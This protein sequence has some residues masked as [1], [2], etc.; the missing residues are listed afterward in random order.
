MSTTL[1]E[2]NIYLEKA[3]LLAE[4][5]AKDAAERDKQGG[6]PKIQRDKIRESGLLKLLIPKEYGGEGQPW[7]LVLEVVREFAKTDAALAHLYGY[8]F[9]CLAGPYLAGSPDQIRHYFTETARHDYFWGN[10][11]NP[12]DKGIIGTR[13]GDQVI[14]NGSKSFSSGSPDSDLLI[15]SW[16]D[17]ETGDYYEGVLPTSRQGVHV[18]DD[19]DNI[20]QRQTGSGTVSFDHVTLNEQEILPT[21]YAA[22]NVFSTII[23]IIS[24]SILTNI[25]IGSALGAI[26]EAKKYTLK[27]SRAWYTS[28]YDKAAQDPWIISRYGNFWIEAQSALSFVEKAALALDRIWERG[29]DLTEEERGESAVIVAGANVLAGRVSLSICGDIFEVMG[30]RASASK[31]G[32]DRFWRNVRTHTLHNPAEYKKRTVGNWVLNGEFPKYGFYS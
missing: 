25:F 9:L 28:G 20:G 11:S 17:A 1:T 21:P 32:Y 19:W 26:E 10:S 5:F 2:S 22:E 13:D 16:N 14:V 31:F 6:T 4:E 8:H 29:F 3:K 27:R 18:H 12:L 23:P 7:S 30:A 15:I 24:Q